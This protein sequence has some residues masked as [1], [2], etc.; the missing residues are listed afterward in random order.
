MGIEA[1]FLF[2]ATAIVLPSTA[3]YELQRAADRA[4]VGG[5]G[6]LVQVCNGTADEVQIQGAIGAL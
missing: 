5:L 2:G 1:E 4:K 6:A 3:P